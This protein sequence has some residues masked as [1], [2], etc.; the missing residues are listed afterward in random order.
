MID[1]PHQRLLRRLAWAC[2]LLMLVVTTTSAWL[3]LAQPRTTCVGWPE[4]RIVTEEGAIGVAAGPASL[5]AA[6]RGAHRI[7]ASAVLLIV[8]AMLAMLAPRSPRAPALIA[9][10]LVLLALALTLAALGIVAPRSQAAAVLLGNLS[11]GLLMLALAWRLLRRLQGPSDPG[12]PVRALAALTAACWLLQAGTGAASAA[13]LSAAA[14]QA[15]LAL[16]LAGLP[17][18]LVTG[19]LARRRGRCGE[20]IALMVA[21][22]AQLLLGA[23]SAVSAAAPPWVLLHNALA[24]VGIALAAGLTIRPDANRPWPS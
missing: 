14:P 17:L 13:G 24:A 15:H 5:Q 3:R 6:A 9:H 16:A 22:A 7:S 18:A 2:V 12:A 21:A 19:W 10:A 23:A 11:G 4:C 20:G 8:L 1:S